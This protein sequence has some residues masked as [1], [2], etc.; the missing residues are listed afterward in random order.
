VGRIKLGVATIG[1]CKYALQLAA[2]YAKER[3]QFQKPIA[4]FGLVSSKLAEMALTTFVGESMGYRTTGLIDDRLRGTTNDADHVAGIEEFSVEASIIKVFGSEAL[5]FCADEAVQ[6][7]GGYGFIEDFHPA[8]LLRDSRIN[9]IFEGTNEINRLIVPGT[10]LKRAIKGDIPLLE[11]SLS[12]R[13]R[14]AGGDIPKPPPGE[15]GVEMQVC[16]LA[17]WI[18]LYV[19]A[20]AGETYQGNV[21]DEQEVLGDIADMISRVYALDSA[22]QR[23]RQVLKDSDERRQK[24]ARDF[25]TA[26]APRAYGFVVHTGR[27]VLMDICDEGSLPGHLDAI[28]KL[29]LDWPTKVIAAKRRIA[30]AVLEADGYPLA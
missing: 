28:N 21:A 14:L 11:H 8:R 17:K 9:R 4:S 18:A 20:V 5:A 15:L 6:V 26:F 23:V 25:L 19:L 24:I 30:A 12:I 29:R 13:E 3:Q 16:E 27:H 7:H 22:V 10:V 2:R 1:G